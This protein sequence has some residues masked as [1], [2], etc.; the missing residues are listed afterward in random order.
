MFLYFIIFRKKIDPDIRPQGQAVIGKEEW[1]VWE[2]REER[3]KADEGGMM[4]GDEQARL[5]QRIVGANQSQ[6]NTSEI[7]G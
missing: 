4:V 2:E 5:R 3:G 7:P 1:G 6:N